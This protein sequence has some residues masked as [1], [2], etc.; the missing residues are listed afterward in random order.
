MLFNVLNAIFVE[1]VVILFWFI[2][3]LQKY[4]FEKNI[5]LKFKL[6]S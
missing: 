3:F 2:F 6:S 1:R 5:Y 4:L